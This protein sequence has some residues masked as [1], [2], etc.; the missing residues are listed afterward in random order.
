MSYTTNFS[1]ELEELAAHADKRLLVQQ[2]ESGLR[3]FGYTNALQPLFLEV[4]QLEEVADAIDT[5]L[6]DWIADK[7]DW[8]SQWQRV[9]FIYQAPQAVLIPVALY[10]NDNGKEWLDCQFGDLFKGTT[11]TDLHADAA[12]YTVFRL[13]SAVY[14]KLAGAHPNSTHRHQLTCWMQQ[15]NQLQHPETGIV[16]LLID[17]H[18]VYV[19]IHHGEWKF[20]QQ[21]EYQSPDD[22]S[23]LILSLLQQA[24]LSP[25]TTPV[26]WSGWMDTSSALYLDLYKYLGKLSLAVLPDRL[27]LNER[28]LQGMQ[29]HF[30]TSLIQAAV[31][32][33]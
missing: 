12:H 5:A 9:D 25:E 8:L 10:G 29:P 32:V 15:L 28:Q 31:C 26:I 7:K 16:Y 11:L 18:L 24:E 6:A 27:Q 19:A 14:S 20:F 2:T 23:Y 17:Q 33:S 4:I 3:L 21:F 1:I 13:S 30:F 22:V